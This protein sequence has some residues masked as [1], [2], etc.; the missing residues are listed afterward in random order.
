MIARTIPTIA[1]VVGIRVH[2]AKYA[3]AA[4]VQGHRD[5]T[6]GTMPSP[7][8]NV[9]FARLVLFL[10]GGIAAV[11]LLVRLEPTLGHLG[12]LHVHK[13][14][15]AASRLGQVAHYPAV[16]QPLRSVNH[17]A[18]HHVHLVHQGPPH[19]QEAGRARWA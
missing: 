13:H 4:S 18:A 11:A 7:V 12:M 9:S 3:L 8:A 19:L 10:P 14:H 16:A 15:R 1:A 5:V 6:Q 2:R 17:Q